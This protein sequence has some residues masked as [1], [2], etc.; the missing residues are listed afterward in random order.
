MLKDLGIAHD[1]RSD[2]SNLVEEFYVPCLSGSVE[3]WRAVGYFTSHGLALAAKG[4]AAFISNGGRMKLVASPLLE[5]EDIEAFTRGYKSRDQILEASVGRQLADQAIEALP[6]ISLHRLEC[7][8]WLIGEGRL[9]IKLAVPS[10]GSMGYGQTLYHEKMG[11][12]FDRHEG[13]IAFTGSSN[14]TVGGLLSNF[15]SLEVYVSWDDP[16]GRVARKVENFQRL[17]HN[18]TPR[19][20]ILDFPEAAKRQLLRLR[21]AQPPSK[22]PESQPKVVF[23]AKQQDSSTALPDIPTDIELRAYQMDACEAWVQS[24][25]QGMLAM[26]T[27]SGKTITSL[28][29]AVRL[30]KERERL[31]VVIACPFQHLVDQWAEDAEHFGF[32]PLRAYESRHTWESTV[33][34]R[35]LDYNLS[36]RSH[37]MVIS[38]HATLA[39]DVMQASLARLSGP[40]L[41]IADEAHHLGAEV[42]RRSLPTQL[43]YRMGLSATPDRW[44][45]D[46]GT[47]ALHQYFGDTVFEFT[48]AE[49]IAQGF[50]S[51]YYYYPHLVELT[52][53]ELEEYEKLTR[54]IARLFDPIGNTRE[55]SLLEFLLRQR[56]DIL[57]RAENKIGTLAELLGSEENIDHALFYCVPG[58]KDQVL[59]LLGN[60]LGLS[61]S[62]FTVEE[63]TEERG[64]L[65]ADFAQ[66]RLQG[67]VAIRCLD[68]GVD[69]PSTQVAYILASTS[70]PREF[71]Q[72]RGR[73]LRKAPGKEHAV[74]HDLIAVPSL[75]NGSR[76]P[77]PEAFDFERRILR[78]ELSRFREFADASLNRFQANEVIWDHAKAY[79]LLDY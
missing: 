58:Q 64:R 63:S 38:T 77:S 51:E 27:G 74:L 78:R 37:V 79:N 1:Y 18:H 2:R 62:Q 36:N 59:S 44:F 46:E 72:R 73:I 25:G 56:A 34:S 48:L 22:D 39:G 11:V 57:N 35:I 76:P 6:D 32:K 28:A 65:L 66:G 55:D 20:A 24:G 21:P 50:L 9:D 7:I 49:A 14:E 3:Y 41:L 67:L 47:E 42:G 61:V 4:L 70:N 10:S 52:N 5:P 54:R 68:E 31:F 69:V 15:E 29:T 23:G 43:H 75:D 33:N 12:F 26:A 16:H 17:W 30:L 53:D 40:S 71:I 19:L 45:D 13:V 60:R 8:A